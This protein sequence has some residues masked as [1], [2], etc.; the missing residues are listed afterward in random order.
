MLKNINSISFKKQIYITIIYSL[1]VTITL[2][3]YQSIKLKEF[4]RK[5]ILAFP[6]LLIILFL[7]IGL[8]YILKPLY[9][10]PGIIAGIIIQDEKK[11]NKI[12]NIYAQIITYSVILIYILLAI[13]LF[14]HE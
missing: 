12:D 2:F 7:L 8:I 9:K 1:I 14:I 13:E 10:I 3:V 4:A 11:I 5:Y 6:F